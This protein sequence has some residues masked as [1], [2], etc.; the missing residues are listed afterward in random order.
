MWSSVSMYI[1][2]ASLLE[3]F[4]VM[5]IPLMQFLDSVIGLLL[6]AV[7]GTFE[8]LRSFV[9]SGRSID[10]RVERVLIVKFFGMGSIAMATP[11][12]AALREKHPSAKI[13]LLTFAPNAEFAEILG[14]FDQVWRLP[15]SHFSEF[16]GRLLTLLP[17][18]RGVRYDVV[19]DLEFFSYFSHLVSYLSGA[20]RRIG[21]ISPLKWRGALSTDKVFFNHYRHMTQVF[22]TQAH[23]LGCAQDPS[24]LARPVLAPSLD[25]RIRQ[26][27]ASRGVPEQ[28]PIIALNPNASNMCL[29][30]RWPAEYFSELVVRLRARYPACWFVF[31]G[32][33]DEKDYVAGILSRFAPEETR[34]IIGLAG[35]LSIPE[36]LAFLKRCSLLIT[37]DSGPSHM[38]NL[39]E[40]PTIIFFGPSP[41]SLLK[42]VGPKHRVLYKGV[43]CSPCL[44]YYTLAGPLCKGDNICMKQISVDETFSAVEEHV[45]RLPSLM[46]AVR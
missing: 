11:T 29:E 16:A 42:P 1:M 22:L 32:A 14:C 12:I 25:D 4:R 35:D 10:E 24:R 30:R 31:V 38:A 36:F 20:R 8:R 6:C 28:A 21:F 17:N 7:L 46:S 3:D 39:M 27:L 41:P 19:L 34:Q 9:W 45:A 26:V 5:S 23:V 2:P 13:D 33:P 44:N 40:L 18:L 37:N 15:T 43:W